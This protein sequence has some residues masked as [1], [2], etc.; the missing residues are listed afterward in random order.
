MIQ[1]MILQ[2]L[3][4]L[5][6]S[7][8]K[9]SSSHWYFDS[10][11]SNHMTSPPKKKFKIKPYDGTIQVHAANGTTIPIT[12]VGDISH[13]LPLNDVF[14]SP[15]LSTNLISVGQLVDGNCNVSFSSSG[16]VV[17]DQET[18][19]VIAKGPKCGRL[20]PL[21]M[22]TPNPDVFVRFYKCLQE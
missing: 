4:T 22:P 5:G 17:Q 2:A 19:R 10:S 20:F 8:K 16:C 11:A 9:Y 13:S 12:S 15:S 18:R 21:H 14:C 7:G 6:I 1:P 3:S